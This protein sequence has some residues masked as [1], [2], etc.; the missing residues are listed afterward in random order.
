MILERFR[1]ADRVEKCRRGIRRPHI[2]KGKGDRPFTR[3][4]LR[5]SKEEGGD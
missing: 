3:R 5:G 1:K 4:E 2:G